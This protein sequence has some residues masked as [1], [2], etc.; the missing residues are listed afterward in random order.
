MLCCLRLFYFSVLM[1]SVLGT[2]ACPDGMD[3]NRGR[4]QLLS[5]SGEYRRLTLRLKFYV[6]FSLQITVELVRCPG[7]ENLWSPPATTDFISSSAG[8]TEATWLRFSQQRR[9]PDWRISWLKISITGSASLTSHMKVEDPW[10]RHV[11]RTFSEPT[12][13]TAPENYQKRQGSPLTSDV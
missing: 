9:R 4:R 1:F 8:R 12:L 6:L 5:R 10:L 7:G 3:G 13:V 2:E 11:I